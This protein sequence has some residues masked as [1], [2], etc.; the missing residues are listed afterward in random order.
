MLAV[1]VRDP[2]EA[3]YTA[4]IVYRIGPGPQI[5]GRWSMLGDQGIVR[6]VIATLL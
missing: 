4:V 3:N 5:V 2:H 6:D 1:A